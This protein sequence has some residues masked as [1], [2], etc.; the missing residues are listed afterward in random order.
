MSFW[1]FSLMA[2]AR[3]LEHLDLDHL[4]VPAGD[5]HVDAALGAAVLDLEAVD[6]AAGDAQVAHH[7]AGGVEAADDGALDDPRGRV[8]VAAGAS[9]CAPFASTVP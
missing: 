1:R 5:A 6:G 3:R 2:D 8:G 7:D 4:R 9:P